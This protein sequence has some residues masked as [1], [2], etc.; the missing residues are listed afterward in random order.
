[1]FLNI[2][3]FTQMNLESSKIFNK[4]YSFCIGFYLIDLL[5]LYIIGNIL[6]LAIGVFITVTLKELSSTI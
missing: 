2:I 5:T 1:M 3:D 4:L 6:L